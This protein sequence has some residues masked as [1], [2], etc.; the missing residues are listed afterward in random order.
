MQAK[1]V[2]E[3]VML[4]TDL[5]TYQSTVGN[6]TAARKSIDARKVTNSKTHLNNRRSFVLSYEHVS[7][8]RVYSVLYRPTLYSVTAD[9]QVRRRLM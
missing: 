5:P 4:S 1:G 6:I 2:S 3:C 7:M 9:I 8:K